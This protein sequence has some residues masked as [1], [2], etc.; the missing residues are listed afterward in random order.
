M[1][2][3]GLDGCLVSPS[4]SAY[5]PPRVTD[6]YSLLASSLNIQAAGR[7]TGLCSKEL[8]KSGHHPLPRLLGPATFARMAEVFTAWVPADAL[9]LHWG[10]AAP[11]WA[12]R[13]WTSRS[14]ASPEEMRQKLPCRAPLHSRVEESPSWVLHWDP[15]LSQLD[16]GRPSHQSQPC[17]LL[18]GVCAQA[19]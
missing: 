9:C 13:E 1:D 11:S 4:P 19:I 18:A 7:A 16:L 2:E 14:A 15:A 17:Q 6:P 10:D 3:M 12:S 5:N 8:D